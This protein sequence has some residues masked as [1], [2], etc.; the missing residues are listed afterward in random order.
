MPTNPVSTLF[1]G[2]KQVT[3][4]LIHALAPAALVLA[5]L[6]PL[7][8]VVAMTP[9]TTDTASPQET[10]PGG[11]PT[12]RQEV[13]SF[14]DGVLAQQMAD[15]SIPGASVA[16]V[17]DGALLF[18]KGYGYADLEQQ[19]AVVADETLFRVGSISKLFTWTAVMQLVELGKLNLHADVNTYLTTFKVPATYPQAITLAHLM[20]HSAGFEERQLGLS[21]LNAA[22]LV[23]LET[24]LANDM[25]ARIYPPGTVT[26]YSNYGTVLAGYIVEKVSGVPFAQYVKTHILQ[27]LNMIESTFQQELSP[28]LLAKRAISYEFINDDDGA[29]SFQALPYEYFQAEPAAGL[30]TTA[31]DMANFMIAHL[32]DGRFGQARILQTETAQEMHRQQFSNDPRVAGMTYGFVE[33]VQNAQHILR[34]TGSTNR[35]AF[36]SYLLLLP[37]Q[38]LGLFVAFNSLGGGP[39][40]FNVADAFLDHY[41]P[42]ALAP[43][44]QPTADFAAR[45]GRYTGDYRS[46]RV[47]QSTIEKFMGLVSPGVKV[48]AASNGTLEIAGEGFGPRPRQWVEIKPLEFIEMGGTDRVVFHENSQGRITALFLDSLPIIGFTKLA[49]YET[50][51]FSYVV[52]TVCVALFIS[53]LLVWPIRWL[54]RR[55]KG[56]SDAPQ[57][58]WAHRLAWTIS[59][60][61][62]LCLILFAIGIADVE[63]G[64]APLAQA[65]L[66]IGLVAA[67]FSVGLI[68]LTVS[69]WKNGYWGLV[70]RLHYSLVTVAAGGFIWFLNQWNLLGFRW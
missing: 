69:V 44:P 25:P 40:K 55:R 56:A 7:N 52:L 42:V 2:I 11:G 28:D 5:L 53:A 12:D 51:S 34:H 46:T 17:K 18:A 57:A 26:A 68:P 49:L 9:L 4:R 50:N 29:G 65:A 41:F 38:K 24:Y 27:P 36:Q 35:E 21:V 16:V 43:S 54:L 67:V 64:I 70:S 32:Q 14:L 60:L 33:L 48:S 23:P 45:A 22:D 30:S 20:T 37:E 61:F 58:A 31:T 39:A 13:E 66:M 6:L 15:Y 19:R 62:I 10:P 3:P 47:A 59:G 63:N 8:S 1:K